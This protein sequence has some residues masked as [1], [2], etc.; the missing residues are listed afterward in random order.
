M[1][2]PGSRR[3][4]RWQS[5]MDAQQPFHSTDESDSDIWDDSYDET[6][7]SKPGKFGELFELGIDQFELFLDITEEEQRLLLA[8]IEESEEDE[9][10]TVNRS[11]FTPQEKWEDMRKNNRQIL[12]K[13]TDS[14]TLQEIDTTL[15]QFLLSEEHSITFK[16]ED[17]MRRLLVH[18]L[19]EFYSL[20]SHSIDENGER[21]TIVRVSAETY[22][23]DDR[24][25]SLIEVLCF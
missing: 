14:K 9:L 16:Y 10:F 25:C 1:G 22:I 19:C 11:M 18:S 21:V 6:Y 13:F 2:K 4:N 8:E 3:Y 20:R 5:D 15:Y 17:G 24:L 23:P 12:K 7:E